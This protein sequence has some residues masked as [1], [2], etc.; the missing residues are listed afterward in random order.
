M[1]RILQVIGGNA[2]A[3]RATV[4]LPDRVPPPANFRGEVLLETANCVA[5]GMCAYVCVSEAIKVLDQ[6]DAMAWTYRPG[7]CTFCAR[8]VERCP[9]QAL[10]MNSDTMR[11]YTKPSELQV[12]QQVAFPRCPDC[13]R[14]VRPAG[15]R[16]T[17]LGFESPGD[18]TRRLL[19]LCE[20]CKRKHIQRNIFASVPQTVEESR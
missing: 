18:D 6:Q 3:K 8:C 10:S 4:R 14:T 13:G 12:E 2:L 16:L 19:T 15:E 7:Q 17:S 20:R 11:T 1:L 5:C 9:G